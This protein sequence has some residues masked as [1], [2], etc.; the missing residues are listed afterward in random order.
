MYL[1][2]SAALKGRIDPW[3]MEHV[4]TSSLVSYQTW[5]KDEKQ[6]GA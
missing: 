6:S 1:N 3:E 2:I 4:S 5:E